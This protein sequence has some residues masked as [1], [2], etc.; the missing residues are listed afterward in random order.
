MIRFEPKT[1]LPEK[2]EENRFKQVKD[3]AIEKR[4]ESEITLD[5]KPKKA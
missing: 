2:K 1:K 5:V 4:K 3:A